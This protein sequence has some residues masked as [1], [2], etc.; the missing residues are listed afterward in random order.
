MYL[1]RF[2]IYRFWEN[3]KIKEIFWLNL[4]KIIM[5]FLIIESYNLIVSI[6]LW[7]GKDYNI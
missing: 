4:F 2:S 3:L 7:N 5:F 6:M 1:S